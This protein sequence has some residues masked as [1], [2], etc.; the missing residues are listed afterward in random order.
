MA[1]SV[2]IKGTREG[3][4]I[5]FGNGE[6]S[7]LLKDL[8][9]HLATR[10]AFFRGGR[11]A[12]QVGERAVE[13]EELSQLQKLLSN[14]GMILR[15]VVSEN[16]V[17]QK[18]SNA[19]G[20][21]LIAPEGDQAAKTQEKP[22]PA[23]PRGP[24]SRQQGESRGILIRRMVRSGQVIRHTGHV[25]ILGDVNAGA[26]IAA[27]GDIVVWGGLYGTA[28]AGFMGDRSAII[29][30]LEMFPLQ[31]RIADFIAR[32]EENPPSKNPY[33]EIARAR[34]GRIVVE[35]WNKTP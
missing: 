11:V 10:G 14:H 2:S 18:A 26:T 7:T 34:G 16:G 9:Q 21:R 19:L 20:L 29:C 5:T 6:F 23:P 35:Q 1:D 28:H 33:P 13:E 12:L 32:P 15:T 4:T 8:D 30:A 17:T 25:V 31:L 27:G 24:A 3:L 22:N